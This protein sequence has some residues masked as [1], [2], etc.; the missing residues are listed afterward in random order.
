VLL[1]TSVGTASAECAWVLGV[2]RGI[3]VDHIYASYPSAQDC[4]RELDTTEQRLRPD[5]TVLTI[6]SAATRLNVTDK[7]KGAFSTMYQCHPDT[8]D[9][10]GPKVK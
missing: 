2:I 1:L 3:K 5:T 9:P 6:R 4:I 8:I 7:I 10:R